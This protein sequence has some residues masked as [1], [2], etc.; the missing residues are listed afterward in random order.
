MTDLVIRFVRDDADILFKLSCSERS[1]QANVTKFEPLSES[2]IHRCTHGENK[3]PRHSP[4]LAITYYNTRNIIF[5]YTTEL[6]RDS[7]D[8]RNVCFRY[9]KMTHPP[10]LL[11]MIPLY[12]A[13]IVMILLAH[14]L[15]FFFIYINLHLYTFIS[16]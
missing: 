8:V 15:P 1:K 12:Y 16:S 5:M 6:V 3:I 14:I 13:L 9:V 10:F 4:I 2:N 11:K 7:T